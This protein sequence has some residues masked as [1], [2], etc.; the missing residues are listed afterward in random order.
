M[1]FVAFAALAGSVSAR[2]KLVTIDSDLWNPRLT[3]KLA[4]SVLDVPG[5]SGTVIG[6][7]APELDDP[8]VNHDTVFH[9]EDATSYPVHPSVRGL[10]TWCGGGVPCRL[11]DPTR[12]PAYC[13][14]FDPYE[15]LSALDIRN[16]ES[17]HRCSCPVGSMR[18]ADSGHGYTC[19]KCPSDKITY[20][21]KAGLKDEAWCFDCPVGQTPSADRGHCVADCV[22]AS[23]GGWTS[24][25][26]DSS[27]M[28]VRD[29]TQDPNFHGRKCP[30]T[31]ERQ[32]CI[33]TAAPT[34]VTA[35]PTVA[36][37]PSPTPDTGLDQ[38]IL[39]AIHGRNTASPTPHPRAPTPA[40][41][42]RP[43]PAPTPFPTPLFQAQITVT[44]LKPVDCKVSAWGAW[45]A[46]PGTC[47]PLGHMPAQRTRIRHPL[48]PAERGGKPCPATHE[49]GS[50]TLVQWCPVDCEMSAWFE[51]GACSDE[52]GG[53]EQFRY[54]A[55]FREAMHGGTACANSRATRACNTQ[56][57]TASLLG[58]S[59]PSTH[60]ELLS[61]LAAKDSALRRFQLHRGALARSCTIT[62]GKMGDK[63]VRH[64]WTG[65]GYG[66]AYCRKCACHDG[67]LLCTKES[68]AD[69]Q[70]AK[71]C[72][73]F[74]CRLK[75]HQ[76][77]NIPV[78]TV[79][80]G[81]GE[82]HGAVHHCQMH[83]Y[84]S[85]SCTCYDDPNLADE[86]EM[87]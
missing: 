1:R 76:T 54:R 3:N 48:S 51:W 79:H 5:E 63:V 4:R 73:H 53:G 30:Q 10:A 49:H 35:A 33:R 16:L 52:C 50:C 32:R 81:V 56:P 20:I 87:P 42:P 60:H 8:L 23:W 26:E 47:T 21:S 37:T 74:T 72:T 65:F 75:F 36:P 2:V 70:G 44:E 24:C 67:K 82:R 71:T 11:L 55:V 22:V 38:H 69:P 19:H 39:A 9:A 7:V 12:P 78:M 13:V 83:S 31:W 29:V 66:S 59:G 41:T 6:A 62:R 34:P 40:P 80:H 85:C 86:T 77:L 46:C 68:C 27:Q 57:C 45:G 64:G 15:P 28:R 58:Q 14:P 18:K 61:E 17:H 84:N 43:T 25:G